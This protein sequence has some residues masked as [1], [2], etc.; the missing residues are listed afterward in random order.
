[1]SNDQYSSTSSLPKDH[2]SRTTD[3]NSTAAPVFLPPKQVLTP[4]GHHKFHGPKA[5]STPGHTSHPPP[6]ASSHF[7]SLAVTVSVGD[8]LMNSI[9]TRGFPRQALLHIACCIHLSQ[10]GHSGTFI[11]RNGQGAFLRILCAA[12]P[13][14][15]LRGILFST[16]RSVPFRRNGVH[17][18]LGSPPS[19]LKLFSPWRSSRLPRT[20]VVAFLQLP[21]RQAPPP[22]FPAFLQ[23]LHTRL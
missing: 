3:I 14:R 19:P 21:P 20:A 2:L 12:P 6:Q 1:M 16:G 8:E 4:E 17:N 18:L 7:Q 9:A 5:L 22:L 10:L 23:I 13:S 11:Q 15:D